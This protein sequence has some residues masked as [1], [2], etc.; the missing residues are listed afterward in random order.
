MLR[1]HQPADVAWRMTPTDVWTLV[2]I[3]DDSARKP[4]MSRDRFNKLRKKH[5]V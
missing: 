2:E 3:E 5:G 1:F 4:S